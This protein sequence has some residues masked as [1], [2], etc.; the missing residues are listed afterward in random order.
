MKTMK[1]IYIIQVLLLLF[2]YTEGKQPELKNFFPDNGNNEKATFA[3]G[4]FWCIEAPFE[5]IDGV[6]SVVSGYSGGKEVSPTYEEVASGSTGHYE[7]VQITYDPAVVS[8]SELLDLF[9]KQFDPTDPGGS[10]YDR[11]SQYKSAI[12]YHDKNQKMIAQ[13]S[14]EALNNTG[15]FKKPIVTDILKFK[16]FYP[17]EDYY[18]DFYKKQSAHYKNYKKASGRDQFILSYWGNWDGSIFNKS[19]KG[20]LKENLT[21]IQ[22]HV[23]QECGTEHAFDNPYW[24]NES[25]GI[26]VDVVSGEPLFSSKDKFKSGTGW[27]SFTKPIDTRH[28]QK[29][30][31]NSYGMKRI[32]VKSYF[33]DSHLGH[34]FSDGPGPG[35]LRYCIN[36]AALLFIPKAEMEEKGYGEYLWLFEESG[37]NEKVR[38][39]HQ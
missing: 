31:D 12:F 18:Q 17:A 28:L 33:G 27:P 36:S 3:G 20:N 39:D 30:A 2:S 8:Y 13:Q 19:S 26:Y 16:S 11:G 10:F 7:S 14:L 34:I 29:K 5:N 23:T 35:Q 1:G 6:I 4:C 9:W 21:D 32:E 15:I 37:N 22:Y 24:N 38:N 25:D